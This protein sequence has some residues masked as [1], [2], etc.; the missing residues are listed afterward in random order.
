MFNKI[1]TL[2]EGKEFRL[3]QTVQRIWGSFEGKEINVLRWIPSEWNIEDALTKR[4][5]QIQRSLNTVRKTGELE[6]DQADVRE[7]CSDT[8]K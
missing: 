7:L 8:G 4:F 6:N 2:H 1:T 5:P 3:R